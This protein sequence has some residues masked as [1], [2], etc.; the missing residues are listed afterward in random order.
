MQ[1]ETHQNATSAATHGIVSARWTSACTELHD[2][3]SHERRQCRLRQRNQ[4]N[5]AVR[6][7]EEKLLNPQIKQ[8]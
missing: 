2:G 4:T 7:K 3:S 8:E 1:R 6:A 5:V